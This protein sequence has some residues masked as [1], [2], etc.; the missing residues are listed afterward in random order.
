MKT[1]LFKYRSI[2]VI[3][4]L[5]VSMVSAH[6]ARLRLPQDF[7]SIDC[8]QYDVS[9]LIQIRD[10]QSQL[11]V[12]TKKRLI[13]QLCLCKDFSQAYTQLISIE[14]ETPEHYHDC[15]L[16]SAQLK[17]F[18]RAEEENQKALQLYPEFTPSERVAQIIDHKKK[19]AAALAQPVA[20]PAVLA[21]PVEQ[22]K[23]QLDPGWVELIA[24]RMIIEHPDAIEK[25]EKHKN[26]VFCAAGA[27]VTVIVCY[28]IYR[29]IKSI[30]RK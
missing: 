15:A 27:T 11:D 18:Q 19:L 30:L 22:P 17:Q 4:S 8:Q 9:E 6:A 2:L 25:L 5:M 13:C 14:E 20:K 21:V 28:G 10:M 16:L 26:K 12:E 3:I 29:T 23:Q 24:A 7:L 1:V